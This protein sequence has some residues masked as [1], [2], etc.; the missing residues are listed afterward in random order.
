MDGHFDIVIIGAGVTGCAIAREL[1]RYRLRV[2]VL[3]KGSDVASGT[4]KANSGI[5]HA[6]FDSK[7]KSLHSK[8]NVDG[9]RMY[10]DLCRELSVDYRAVGSLVVAT[11]PEEQEMLRTLLARGIANGV[12]GLR[13]IGEKELREMEPNLSDSAVEALWAPYS[14]VVSPYELTIALAESAASNGVTFMLGVGFRGMSKGDDG[15]LK[16]DTDGGPLT[17]RVLINAAGLYSD[18]IGR[19]AGDLFDIVPIKG[20]EAILDKRVGDLVKHVIFP[21]PTP[22]SK[23]MLVSPTA[24]GNLLIGPT[25]EV[26]EP[27][28]DL[29]TTGLGLRQILAAAQ[30]LVPKV[31]AANVITSYAGLRATPKSGD[32]IIQHSA[33][34]PGVIHVAGIKSPGLTAAPA[35]GVMVTGMVREFLGTMPVNEGYRPERYMPKPFREMSSQERAEAIAADPLYGHVVCRCETVTEAEIV[36]AIRSH[37]PADNLDSLKRRTRAGMGRCQGAFCGVKLAQILARELDV[38][39]DH[40]TKRGGDT[41]L[42]GEP[43]KSRYVKEAKADGAV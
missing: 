1:S 13:L 26:I 5:V 40:V 11:T 37:I 32:F 16:L 12:M 15:L 28:D 35:I 23:G 18:Q 2:A 19:M 33:A 21:V 34:T 41:W 8:L 7:E 14:G 43:T 29:A 36:A 39:L 27:R 20:Q 22:I 38:P 24:H 25:A 3:E 4:S 17:A 6:G 9:L 10:P 30:H 31:S 42:F